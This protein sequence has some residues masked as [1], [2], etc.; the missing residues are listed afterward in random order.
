MIN[1]KPAWTNIT[2]KDLKSDRD[3]EIPCLYPFVQVV[4]W[5][6]KTIIILLSGM[7]SGNDFI[8]DISDSINNSDTPEWHSE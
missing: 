7:L 4:N 2:Q 8:L 1:M 5:Q 6:Q 3:K